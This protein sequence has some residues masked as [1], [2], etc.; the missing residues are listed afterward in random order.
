MSKR[1]IQPHWR[2]DFKIE[3]TLPDIK[4]VRTDFIINSIAVAV[5]LVAVFSLLKQE[6]SAHVLR[7]SV[8]VLEERISASSADDQLHLTR[9]EAFY[10]S[11]Q[12]VVELQRFHRAPFVAH[13]LFAS[14]ASLKPEGMVLTRATFSETIDK[15]KKGAST[16]VYTIKL[17]G[18]VEDLTILSDLKDVLQSSP[19]LTAEGFTLTVD[20]SIQR[21]NIE[22]GITPFHIL[23]SLRSGVA[24]KGGKK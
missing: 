14:L 13:E 8:A 10:K 24:A 5:A 22:T 20:E 4:V 6:Y 1:D 21:R 3:S 9:S 19:S 11:A 23:I 18:S 16:M 7:N 15:P 12:R 17:D 2:P